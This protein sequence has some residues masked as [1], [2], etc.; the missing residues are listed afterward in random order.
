MKAEPSLNG[1]L[2]F[3]ALA[4]LVICVL[5]CTSFSPDDSKVLFS[6][7][8]P[9]AQAYGVGLY[10][11]STRTTATLFVPQ[12]HQ[13][14]SS[15]GDPALIRA[16]WLADGRHILVSWGRDVEDD[17]L[18]LAV[19]PYGHVGPTRFIHLEGLDEGVS[20]M[21]MPLATAGG[22]LFLRGESN[23]LVRVNLLTGEV[24]QR[25]MSK[26]VVPYASPGGDRAFYL[27]RID[28]DESKWEFGLIDVDTWDL[29]PTARFELDE[30]LK[31]AELAAVS[32]DGKWAIGHQ[33]DPPQVLFLEG[34]EVK[35]RVALGGEGEEV[36]VNVFA[37][38]PRN[39]TAYAPYWKKTKGD[40][41]IEA[42]ILELPFPDGELRRVP[43]IGR[44]ELGEGAGAW[45][46]QPSVSHDGKTLAIASTYLVAG[47]AQV[48]KN[49]CALFLVDLSDP[50]RQVTRVPVPWPPNAL[51]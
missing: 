23:T 5:A 43:L 4:A 12:V 20:Q 51:D 30:S 3:T 21:R 11:R 18:D 7:Y 14:D 25:A 42:G 16:Q 10:D 44:V 9:E 37:I 48:A 49:D 50:G 45:C 34:G 2:S 36:S 32:P 39:H 19:L 41:H 35:R 47:D 24:S 8:D 1:M 28:E 13:S 33:E 22:L 40:T 29:K 27:S 38:S 26:D 46:F 31:D 15:G 17:D 6:T